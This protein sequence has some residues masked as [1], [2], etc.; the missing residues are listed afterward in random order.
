MKKLTQRLA[1]AFIAPFF[2]L[3]LTGAAL[4]QSSNANCTLAGCVQNYTQNGIQSFVKTYKA[5]LA[6]TNLGVLGQTI[7]AG[8]VFTITGSATRTIRVAKITVTA[9]L[10]TTTAGYGT[11]ALVRRAAADTGGTPVALSSFARDTLNG[12]ATAG[13]TLYSAAPTVNSTVGTLDSCR[14]FF[15][16][17]AAVPDVC[18]FTLGVNNDQMTVLRGATDILALAFVVDGTTGA[19]IT[20]DIDVEWTEEP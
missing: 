3:L 5:A 2:A 19:P 1:A 16:T 13:I 7:V 20:A 10:A 17:A 18:A 4:A 12:A 9:R 6:S 15:P 11:V 14:L 8:D